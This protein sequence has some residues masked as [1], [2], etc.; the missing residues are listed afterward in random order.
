MAAGC[1]GLVIVRDTETGEEIRRFSGGAGCIQG[2][3]FSPDGKQI[4]TTSNQ[5]AL[6]VW[7]FETGRELLTLPGSSAIQFTPDG[8]HLISVVSDTV[9]VYLLQL[10]D[11]ITLAKSRLT[12]SL[13]PEECQEYLHM[14]QCLSA[15]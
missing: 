4:A 13:T 3:A 8:T 11:L 5:R 14:D 7:D 1:T 10:E 6:R 9:Q 2:V 12:R 15:P